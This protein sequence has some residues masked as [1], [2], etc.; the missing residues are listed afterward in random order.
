MKQ[1]NLFEEKIALSKR[2]KRFLKNAKFFKEY[3]NVHTAIQIKNGMKWPGNFYHITRRNQLW[4]IGPFP[5]SN[6]SLEGID[7]VS[8]LKRYFNENQSKYREREN[9]LNHCS[10]DFKKTSQ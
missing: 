6:Q 8:D 1:L 3:M 9:L 10:Q 5:T 4:F 7:R 2:T